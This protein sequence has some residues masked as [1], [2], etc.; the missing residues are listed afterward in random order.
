MKVKSLGESLQ[1]ARKSLE[2]AR[3]RLEKARKSPEKARKSLGKARK[4]LEKKTRKSLDF[5][6]RFPCL[7]GLRFTITNIPMNMMGLC[8][9]YQNMLLIKIIKMIKTSN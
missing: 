1:K 9:W 3:K 6:K 5:R 7:N 8:R 2:K 4:S